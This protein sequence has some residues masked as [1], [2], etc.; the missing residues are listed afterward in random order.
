MKSND[1]SEIPDSGETSDKEEDYEKEL[2]S[3]LVL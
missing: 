3:Y 2:V 1:N